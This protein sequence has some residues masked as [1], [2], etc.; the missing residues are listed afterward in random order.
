MNEIAKQSASKKL[1]E[2]IQR[3]GISINDT[4]S[5]LGIKGIY[6]TMARRQ[7]YFDKM[8][9]EAWEKI[10]K[11][12]NSGYSLK[13]YPKHCREAGPCVSAKETIN[14]KSEGIFKNATEAF[15]EPEEQQKGAPFD[16][17]I[18]PPEHIASGDPADDEITNIDDL[19]EK[20]NKRIPSLMERIEMQAKA[21]NKVVKDFIEANSSCVVTDDVNVR[22]HYLPFWFKLTKGEESFEFISFHRLPEELKEAIKTMRGE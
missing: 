9:K 7:K 16:E 12:V 15:K 5:A 8:S 3:E 11:W 2:A 6:V 21:D 19:F 17:E 22:Y 20:P 10:L 4:A 14:L 13:E 18:E 1:E